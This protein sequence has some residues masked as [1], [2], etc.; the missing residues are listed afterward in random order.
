[1]SAAPPYLH[2]HLLSSF[3]DK[4]SA[5]EK[6]KHK[7]KTH[8]SRTCV[9]QT[10]AGAS[11]N[12]HKNESVFAVQSE[13]NREP[14][15]ELYNN[16][17]NEKRREKWEIRLHC[18]RRCRQ[19]ANIYK[20]TYLP[21]CFHPAALPKAWLARYVYISVRVCVCEPLLEGS[22][23]DFFQ[24]GDWK[25]G[26]SHYSLRITQSTPKWG[27]R[28][29]QRTWTWQP[30]RGFYVFAWVRAPAGSSRWPSFSEPPHHDLFTAPLPNLSLHTHT[31]M[32]KSM[33][34]SISMIRQD[35][36]MWMVFFFFFHSGQQGENGGEENRSVTL[37]L[38]AVASYFPLHFSARCPLLILVLSP[39][40]T[41]ASHLLSLILALTVPP[42]L[43]FSL[44]AGQTDKS[45][46]HH[47]LLSFLSLVHS[48]LLLLFSLFLSFIHFL[49][50]SLF[51]SPVLHWVCVCV[52]RRLAE[53]SRSRVNFSLPSH[54]SQQAREKAKPAEIYKNK[55]ADFF[56][57]F[58][59]FFAGYKWP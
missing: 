9:G 18:T 39:E 43:T 37:A 41:S 49:S 56:F 3:P 52:N 22:V 14:R 7:T 51:H 40:P 25:W 35:R 44:E 53:L 13:Q 17:N 23:C 19:T 26:R 27:A 45:R 46:S 10:R 34:S 12:I 31:H 24:T 5:G 47:L 58:F 11:L 1:M 4:S 20:R 29:C 59:Y 57:F 28:A 15:P 50:L 36:R 6:K 2:T 30:A 33:I 38:T 32:A 54:W 16:G 55:N 48:L 42:I 8:N 21:D